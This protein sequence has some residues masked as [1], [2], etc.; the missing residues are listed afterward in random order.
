MNTT[1][2]MCGLILAL[3]LGCEPVASCDQRGHV[4]YLPQPSDVVV[5]ELDGRPKTT[6][7][8]SRLRDVLVEWTN[9]TPHAFVWDCGDAGSYLAEWPIGIG[10]CPQE[11]DVTVLNPASGMLSSYNIKAIAGVSEGRQANWDVPLRGKVVQVV[12][13]I[14][15]E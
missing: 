14:G 11:A 13:R 4:A 3:C 2:V 10:I 9:A 5:R 6:Y 12:L 8:V 7:G 1:Y 15:A